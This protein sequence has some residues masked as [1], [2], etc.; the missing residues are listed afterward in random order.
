MTIQKFQVL[1]RTI[2]IVAAVFAVFLSATGLLLNHTDRLDLGNI[3]LDN[4]WL[5]EWYELAPVQEPEAFQAGDHW[6]SRIDS[7][8]YF[9]A[10][11]LEINISGLTGAVQADGM[12]IAA[13]DDSLLLLTSQG[14]L[15]E[16]LTAVDNLPG[17]ITGIGLKD[18]V[19]PVLMTAN[20]IFVTDSELLVWVPTT[21][22]AADWSVAGQL[23]D[24]LLARLLQSYRGNGV[25]LERFIL[26]LHSGRIFGGM[27]RLAADI[28]ALLLLF[29]AVSGLWV[30][31]LRR[32]LNLGI[33]EDSEYQ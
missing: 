13:L 8:L 25:S 21:V 20:G 10:M 23:P 6:I 27:G 12:I 33:A 1:H 19:S 30:L 16:R 24:D 14:E 2:G 26:D 3:H 5:L 28:A 22:T 4:K 32:R 7:R 18:E 31:W 9:D 17:E 11:D 29:L 15:I